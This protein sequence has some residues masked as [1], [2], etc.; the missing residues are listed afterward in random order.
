MRSGTVMAILYF[1]MYIYF[2]NKLCFYGDFYFTVIFFDNYVLFHG[3][4]FF[5]SNASIRLAEVLYILLFAVYIL[6]YTLIYTLTIIK[7]V[8]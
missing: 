1:T 2:E 3:S 7:Y 5:L 8:F 6:I 4:V